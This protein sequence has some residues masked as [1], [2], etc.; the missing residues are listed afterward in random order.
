MGV[1]QGIVAS[2]GITGSTSSGT[3]SDFFSLPQMPQHRYSTK[4]TTVHNS[5]RYWAWEQSTKLVV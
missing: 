1:S 5:G 3:F 4:T 2:N